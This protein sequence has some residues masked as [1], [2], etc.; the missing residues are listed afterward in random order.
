MRCARGIPEGSGKSCV[1]EVAEDRACRVSSSQK[2]LSRDLT[3]CV[4]RSQ[5]RS[6]QRQPTKLKHVSSPRM[7]SWPAV[8]PVII[9][10]SVDRIPS[11]PWGDI[12]TSRT[13]RMLSLGTYDGYA[14][15]VDRGSARLID[16]VFTTEGLHYPRRADAHLRHLTWTGCRTYECRGDSQIQQCT[17]KTVVRR[18]RLTSVV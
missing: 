13:S 4:R 6:T 8:M 12:E 17:T 7:N 10:S 18:G 1:S 5:I 16:R 15:I 3:E 2:S 14:S 9:A 11:S